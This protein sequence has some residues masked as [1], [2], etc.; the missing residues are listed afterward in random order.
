MRDVA[1]GQ[2]DQLEPLIRRYASPLL[3]FIQKMIG[4]RHRSE[5]L[6]Q[7]VFLTV[8][9]KRRQYQPGRA[10]K[11]WLYA[12][13]VNKCRADFRS[14]MGYVAISL[15]DDFPALPATSPSSPID[16]AISTETTT[17]ISAAVDRLPIKQRAVVV[18]RIWGGL[19]Y[20]EIAETV[21]RT[22]ETVRSNMHHGLA[23]MREYLEPRLR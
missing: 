7:E 15:D 4:D 16:T 3:T 22:E 23:A 9:R 1:E 10:F 21:G 14:R 2:R 18:L 20:G 5:E 8:W 11:P 6:F 13:A 12:I 19:S 17:I